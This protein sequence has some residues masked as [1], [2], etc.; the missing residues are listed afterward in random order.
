MRWHYRDPA[1]VWLFVA[2]Y[3]AH[4]IEEYA[5]GFPDWFARLSGAPLPVPAFLAINAVAFIVLVAVVAAVTRREACGWMAIGVATVALVNSVGHLL[6]SLLTGTYSPGLI[7]GVVLYMPLGQLALIRAW[8]QAPPETFRRGVI[9]GL[10][11]QAAVALTA[12]A[13][14]SAR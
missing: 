12:L 8:H 3:L 6:G 5:G 7:T 10:L 2:A 13:V 1:L 11:A 9:A 14:A 4:L